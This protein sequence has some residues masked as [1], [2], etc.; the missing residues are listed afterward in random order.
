MYYW[1]HCSL[2]ICEVLLLPAILWNRRGALYSNT[3][4]LFYCKCKRLRGSS[5]SF[6][7]QFIAVRLST[8]KSIRGSREWLRGLFSVLASHPRRTPRRHVIGSSWKQRWSD[9]MTLPYSGH[10]GKL[11]VNSL[12]TLL[13]YRLVLGLKLHTILLR[14]RSRRTM[15]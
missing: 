11:K 2:G 14:T 15:R 12:C 10:S 4:S 3:H 13:D 6:F 9:S 1:A 7:G 5:S 8:L